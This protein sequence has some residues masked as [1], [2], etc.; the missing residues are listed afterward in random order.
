MKAGFTPP[1]SAA[2]SRRFS[3]LPVFEPVLVR[4]RADSKLRVIFRVISEFV[5]ITTCGTP[6]YTAN[7]SY[8]DEHYEILRGYPGFVV[9]LD[10]P[11]A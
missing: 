4:N 8:L 9:G 2:T 6:T 5:V 1:A 10:V 11:A 7:A 3:T